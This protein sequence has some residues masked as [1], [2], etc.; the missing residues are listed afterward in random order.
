[1]IKSVLCH[2]FF[3]TFSPSSVGLK[4]ISDSAEWYPVYWSA[5]KVRLE[6]GLFEVV[7][8]RT[9]SVPDSI[10]VHLPSVK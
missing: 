4:S 2:G 10:D 1:M 6:F 9:V 7:S 8:L 5:D 3:Q